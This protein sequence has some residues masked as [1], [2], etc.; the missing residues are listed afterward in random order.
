MC[1]RDWKGEIVIT[2]ERFRAGKRGGGGERK[3]DEE[4]ER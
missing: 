1:N 3:R 2:R 4:K